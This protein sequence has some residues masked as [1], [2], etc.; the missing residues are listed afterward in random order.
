MVDLQEPPKTTYSIQEQETIS[1]Q[2]TLILHSF[3]ILYLAI[4]NLIIPSVLN[5]FR[6]DNLL[7]DVHFWFLFQIPLYYYI[8]NN[9]KIA[10]EVWQFFVAG[11]LARVIFETY[12]VTQFKSW[13]YFSVLV[14]EIASLVFYFFLYK[15]TLR[16][17][18]FLMVIPA[19]IIVFTFTQIELRSPWS[20]KQSVFLKA[21]IFDDSRTL[22]CTGSIVRLHPVEVDSEVAITDC[23]FSSSLTRFS[24][25]LSVINNYKTINLRLYRLVKRAHGVS[26]KFAR[27]FQVK[28][29]GT[30]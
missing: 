12:F 22:G 29:G 14:S 23:G 20:I 11:S 26:W 1:H 6:G 5:I 30:K 7:I 21:P 2:F 3:L 27:L 28:K 10:Q 18:N 13:E 16:P 15:R 9:K 4:H 8:K 25:D 17:R 24:E 19:I